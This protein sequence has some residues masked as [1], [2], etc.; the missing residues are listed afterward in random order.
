MKAKVSNFIVN[1]E[2]MR[3]SEYEIKILNIPE[4]GN[5]VQG[6]YCNWNGYRF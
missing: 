1:V 2:P 6:Y 4:S 5:D 3:R